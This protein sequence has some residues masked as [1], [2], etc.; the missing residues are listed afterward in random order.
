MTELILD[1]LPDKNGKVRAKD[2]INTTA[3]VVK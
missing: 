2:F 3:S 1:F